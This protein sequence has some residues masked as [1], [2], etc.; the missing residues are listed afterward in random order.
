MFVIR[1]T[2]QIATKSGPLDPLLIIKIL[3]KIQEIQNPVLKYCRTSQNY[4]FRLFESVGKDGHRQMVKI[5]LKI[6]KIMELRSIS[7]KKHEVKTW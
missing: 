4:G 1:G 2:L 6:M 5:R 7:I 3:L